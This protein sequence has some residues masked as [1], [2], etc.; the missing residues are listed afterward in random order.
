MTFFKRLDQLEQ[1]S[2]ARDAAPDELL[3]FQTPS[4]V[5]VL[6]AEQVNA[7]RRDVLAEPMEKAKTL[8]ALAT[9]S[10]RAMEAKDV[11]ARLDTVE[12]VL[13]QR[14]QMNKRRR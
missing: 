2:R 7:V 10:L 1:Q 13:K 14:R 8:A 12:Q 11:R 6:L 5:L 3:P 4:D 9:L